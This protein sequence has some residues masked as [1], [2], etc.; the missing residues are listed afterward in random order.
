MRLLHQSNYQVKV[1]RRRA[2]KVKT[3]F[4]KAL[5]EQDEEVVF[6]TAITYAE[7]ERTVT[8]KTNNSDP[9]RIN[10]EL[11]NKPRQSMPGISQQHQ[12]VGYTLGQ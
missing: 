10:I 4:A 7:D 3:Q 9:Q 6:N 12:N 2:T 5:A 8:A 1:E 11:V